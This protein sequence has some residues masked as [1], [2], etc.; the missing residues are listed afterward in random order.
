MKEKGLLI[1]V[2]GCSGAGK[3]TVLAELFAKADRLSYSVSATTRLPRP[4]EIDGVNYHFV[5]KE[6]F[7]DMIAKG[8]IL[9]YTTYA[10]NY[11]GT[12]KSELKKTESGDSLILEIELEGATNV[13]RM[14][15]DAVTIVIVPPSLEVL[16]N[17]LRSR[18]TNTE[19]DIARRMKQAAV[20]LR[21]IT[22]YE[23]IVL[24]ET[25]HADRA[26]DEILA[27]IRAEQSKTARNPDLVGSLTVNN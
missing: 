17:R 16:E 14:V 21:H 4:G 22:D 13:K 12:P 1:V 2:S 9:E 10:G 24:N 25:G 11:Y 15:P 6:T 3:G 23:Y 8:E 20:E 19:E 26:A 18:G 5:T 27:I 7:E